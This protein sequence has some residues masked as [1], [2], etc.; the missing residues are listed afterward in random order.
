MR[1]RYVASWMLRKSA[2]AEGRSG[3]Q[4]RV[5]FDSTDPIALRRCRTRA[6]GGN[7]ATKGGRPIRRSGHWSN[8]SHPGRSRQVNNITRGGVLQ[9]KGAPLLFQQV[10][11]EAPT[12]PALSNPPFENRIGDSACHAPL[13]C[14]RSYG[15]GVVGRLSCAECSAR[16]AASRLSS[17]ALPP[18]QNQL[19]LAFLHHH[20]RCFRGDYAAAPIGGPVGP[21]RRPLPATLSPH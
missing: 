14:P 7:G 8:H 1:T 15:L 11:Q 4:R 10:G 13:A 6:G 9:C 3:A 5:H 17:S 21:L 16:G 12:L 20:S 2:L 19:L 18:L